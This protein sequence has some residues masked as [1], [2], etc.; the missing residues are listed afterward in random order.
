LAIEVPLA[1]EL[2]TCL[3]CGY[4]KAVC[5]TWREIGWE[6]A[7]PRGRAIWLSRMARRTPMDRFLGFKAEP[8]R[9]FYEHFYY[10]TTCGL[11]SEVCHTSIPLLHVWERAREQFI[12]SGWSLL[13]P[14]AAMATSVRANHNPW[15]EPAEKRT[16]WMG[17]RRPR[18]SADVLWFVGRSESYTQFQAAEAGA[19]LM[20]AAGV[21]WTTLGGEEW[22]CGS[23]YVKIGA[24]E[25]LEDNARHNVDAIEATGATR[26]V[27]GCP[28]CLI[29]MTGAY[30]DRGLAG[31]FEVVHLTEFLVEQVAKG[32]LS[33]GKGFRGKVIWHDPCELGRV[34]PRVYEAPRR[35]LDAVCGKGNWLEFPDNRDLGRCC[36][37]GGTFK[38]VDDDAAVS[39]GARMLELAER[40]GAD[41]L[42][43]ACPTCRFNFNHSVQS[44]KRRRKEAGEGR[45]KMRVFDLKELLARSL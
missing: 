1:E 29:T 4:C 38:A 45:F 3:R 44:I 20:D 11:C 39:I 41:T 32:A 24:T 36:G 21:E 26:V 42:V 12:R 25:G 28:G 31:D 10:C 43:T 8:T 13:E 40:L 9:R 5:P 35:I 30:H 6:S 14:H 17:E 33:P 7:S 18:P 2:D 27:T 22:C 37:G 19:A 16:E 23:P 34:G 15:G